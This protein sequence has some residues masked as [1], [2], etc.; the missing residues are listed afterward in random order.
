MCPSCGFATGEIS[1]EDLEEYQRRKLRDRIYR[2][3]MA[4]YLAISVFLAAF[5][6]YWWDTAGFVRASGSGPVIAI[7]LATVAYLTIRVYLFLA[8][9]EVKKLRAG[10]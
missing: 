8:Q 3:K 6:W 9:R 7:G 5:G 1:D 10:S 2:L 4:S